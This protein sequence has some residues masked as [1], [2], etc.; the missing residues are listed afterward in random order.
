MSESGPGQG[1]GFKLPLVSVIIVNF[2]YGRYLE[3]AVR[4]V[5]EQT[6]KNVE[7]IL[8]DNAS[9]DDSALT[10]ADLET[11]YPTLRVVRRADNGG[12]SLASLEGFL[13]TSGPYVCFLDADDVM[14]PTFLATHLFVHL[15]LREPIG[16]TCS[17]MFQTLGD[18]LVLGTF[19][20]LN[21]FVQS[22]PTRSRTI[23]RPLDQAG[24][25]LPLGSLASVSEDAVH[26]VAADQVEWPWA[27]M[28][29]F[30]FRRDALNLVMNN[31][32]LRTL[33]S[34]F[35]VY[36]ARSVNVLT[37]SAI[38]DRTLTVYR[39]HSSNVF[40]RHPQLAKVFNFER[41]GSHDH[42]QHARRIIIDHLFD[43]AD[44]LLRKL[45]NQADFFRA[46]RLL[47]DIKPVP[48]SKTRQGYT[49]LQEKFVDALPRL[50]GYV[51]LALLVY[52]AVSIR[53]SPI[54]VLLP[55]AAS[56]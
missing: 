27:S 3:A 2:N 24:D 16:F 14:L 13:A 26:M 32:A 54:R 19:V 23:M 35:D 17:D 52:W 29:A 45:Q 37:G 43:K 25:S 30:V 1:F 36:L 18:D 50:R 46:V 5:Y 6:Y 47:S 22:R 31:P 39:M 49:H 7:V 20:A 8:L 34:N 44:L 38:I 10:I 53:V 41:H 55:R 33:A 40:A 12:Q 4:S 11:R 56:V 42:E 48:M 21:A 51:P 15:S 28:S 9:T